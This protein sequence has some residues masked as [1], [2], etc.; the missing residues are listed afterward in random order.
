MGDYIACCNEE[1]ELLRS[2]CLKKREQFEVPDNCF[3]HF[4]IPLTLEHEQEL[5]K[6]A[7]FKVEKVLDEPD[8]ATIIIAKKEV[9]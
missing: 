6:N 7:G 4:D 3:V 2:V 9:N 8:G 1:E 5:L